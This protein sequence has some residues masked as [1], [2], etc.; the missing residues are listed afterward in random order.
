MEWIQY[1]VAYIG[2]GVMS[3]AALVCALF[4]EFKEGPD[5][6]LFSGFKWSRLLIVCLCWP[7][8]CGF[9]IK[10]MLKCKFRSW[11]MQLLDEQRRNLD[12]SRS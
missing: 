6:E 7:W 11:W 5:S 9:C 8:L 10:C 3:S 4:L 12:K 2:I 1:I